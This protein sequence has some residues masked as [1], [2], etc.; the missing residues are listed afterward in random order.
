MKS[1]ITGHQALHATAII[2]LQDRNTNP[3]NYLSM[4]LS[5]FRLASASRSINRTTPML[6]DSS[7]I[8]PHTRK[9]EQVCRMAARTVRTQQKHGKKG[10]VRFISSC[11]SKQN[12]VATPKGAVISI[13]N[14]LNFIK[15]SDS[16]THHPVEE[17][18]TGLLE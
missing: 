5:C 11:G 18:V 10:R 6:R 15:R 7:N 14:P 16:C 9:Q 2:G 12:H 13:G 3:N 17:G 8:S 4:G 1:H